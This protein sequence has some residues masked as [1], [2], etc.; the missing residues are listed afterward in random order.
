MERMV[1]ARSGLCASEPFFWTLATRLEFI[2]DEKTKTTATDGRKLRFNPE[3]AEATPMP[4]LE[5]VIAH[6]VLS[7]ALG[8]PLRREGRDAKTWND[9][10]D[11]VVNAEL[12]RAGFQLPEGSLLDPRFDGMHTEMVYKQLKDE[13]SEEQQGDDQNQAGGDD[14]GQ[15]SSGQSGQEPGDPSGKGD[16]ATGHFDDATG[17]DGQPADAAERA[18]Q[19]EEWQVAVAQAA[20]V[21]KACGKLPGGI[22]RAVDELLNPKVNWREALQRYF[23]QRA[24][25]DYSWSRPNRRFAHRGLYLP[26]LDGMKIGKLAFAIDMSGSIGQDEINQFCSEMED[27]RRTIK[28]EEV[29]ALCFDTQV[30]EVLRF[31]EDDPIEVKAHAGGG[32][33]FDDP[34]R[35]LEELGIE[36][37]AL[38]YLTDLD[39]S[40]FPPEPPYPVLWVSNFKQH[41]PFGDVIM[42]AD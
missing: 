8:H 39:S 34:P 19:E 17:E 36:P 27:V 22:E 4:E 37:E 11:Y 33:A 16:D 42:M 20:Q 41:A 15:G 32:T 35:V 40:A 28:P 10:S 23:K 38:V 5:A 21:A 9:A 12:Q 26:S 7:C 14:Q 18:E 25:D 3:W 30:K 6:H 1:K 13:Q 2:A 29:I 31:G 24:K